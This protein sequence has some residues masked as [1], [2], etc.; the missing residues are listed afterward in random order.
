MIE[1]PPSEKK[2]SA[3]PTPS[4]F[5]TCSQMPASFFSVAVSGGRLSAS[6]SD[7]RGSNAGRALRSTL[8]DDVRGSSSSRMKADGTM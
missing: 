6:S 1:S 3:V 8:P 2:F 5:S 4:S 7:S